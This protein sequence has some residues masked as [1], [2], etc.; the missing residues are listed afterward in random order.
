M[1][2]QRVMVTTTT[3]IGGNATSVVTVLDFSDSGVRADEFAREAQ[4]AIE[5]NKCPSSKSGSGF[6][7]GLSVHHTAILLP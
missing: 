4:A 7:S 1:I 5:V 6:T 3:H 2:A